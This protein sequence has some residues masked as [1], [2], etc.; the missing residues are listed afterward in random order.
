MATAYPSGSSWSAYPFPSSIGL[1]E[2][3]QGYPTFDEAQAE[4]YYQKVN[5]RVGDLIEEVIVKW[6]RAGL[7]VN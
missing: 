2:P 5:K 4:E 1:Y 3:G 7:Y 6:E